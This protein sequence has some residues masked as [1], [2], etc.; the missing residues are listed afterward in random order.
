MWTALWRGLRG[1]EGKG[2]SNP[3]ACEDP[4]PAKDH[5]KE[6]RAFGETAVLPNTW[7]QPF[8]RAWHME[9]YYALK[10][11]PQSWRVEVLTPTWLYLEIGGCKKDT[12]VKWGHKGRVLM[13]WDW[14][15]YKK[16]KR[17]QKT[18]SLG[19]HRRKA[20]GGH[21]EKVADYKAGRKPSPTWMTLGSWTSS[22]QN[23]EKINVYGLSQPVCWSV[24][25]CFGNPSKL[26]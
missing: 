24:V 13:Y 19:T 15:P 16:E 6:L 20:V 1:K 22:L 26:I 3:T 14:C 23:C 9:T 18:L 25:V 11:A 17:K 5:V 21:W 12:K 8:E 10:C 7:L 4:S 2:G